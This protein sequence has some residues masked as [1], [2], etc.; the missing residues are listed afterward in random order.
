MAEAN[1]IGIVRVACCKGTKVIV[2]EAKMTS[3]VSPTKSTASLRM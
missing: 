1:T 3:G 2:V